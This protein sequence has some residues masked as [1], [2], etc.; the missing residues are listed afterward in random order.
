MLK[1]RHTTQLERPGSHINA[2]CMST[3]GL[4]FTENL[5]PNI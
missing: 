5:D 2:L 4:R 1:R 3:L